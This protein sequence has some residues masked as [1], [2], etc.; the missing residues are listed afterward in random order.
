VPPLIQVAAVAIDDDNKRAIITAVGGAEFEVNDD[1]VHPVQVSSSGRRLLQ[2]RC[3]QRPAAPCR[4]ARV[5]IG[6][7]RVPL[8]A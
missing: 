7:R 6:G 2:V 4:S 5:P 3:Q 8:A 1:G